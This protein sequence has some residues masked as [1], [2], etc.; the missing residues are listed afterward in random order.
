MIKRKEN[1]TLGQIYFERE[2]KS[3][4][5]YTGANLALKKNAKSEE[6]AMEKAKRENSIKLGQIS[7][8][9]VRN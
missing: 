4:K 7:L 8:S 1:P 2:R 6:D 9:F 3:R 5:P